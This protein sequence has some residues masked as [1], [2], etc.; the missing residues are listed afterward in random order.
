MYRSFDPAA[1]GISGRQSEIIELALTYGFNGLVLDFPELL[2]RAEERGVDAATRFLSSAQLKID[3]FRL[4]EAWRQ[5]EETF[6]ASLGSIAASAHIA[7][8]AGVELC[9]ATI[10][11]ATDFYP[12]HENFELHRKRLGEIADVLALHN[13]KLALDFLVAPTHREGR[14]FQFIADAEAMVLLIKAI[15]SPNV[16]LALDCW[17][18]HFGGG[19]TETLTALDPKRVFRCSIA[20]ARPGTTLEGLTDEMRVMPHDEGIVEIVPILEVLRDSAFAGP[21]TMTPHASCF[22]DLKRDA[23]LEQCRTAYDQLWEAAGL[24]KPG[25]MAAANA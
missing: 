19:T 20:D 16:G 21:V 1:L 14:E 8:A 7:A 17:N 12:Y 5:D 22:G 23:I 3:G 13:V 11:P 9:H 4:P 25:K 24:A 6:K 10:L 15:A 18:W 2:K